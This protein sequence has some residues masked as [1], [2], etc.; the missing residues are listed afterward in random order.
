MLKKS[1]SELIC[2]KF[3]IPLESLSSTPL[4]Q[5]TGNTL[6]SIDGCMSIKKYETDEIIIRSKEYLL[7][8]KGY[9]L[10]MLTFSQGRVNI[11]GEIF[12][13]SIERA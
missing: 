8:I 13:Y 1:F 9:E 4:V 12:S 2:D 7:S 11:K 5:I 6:M 10:S 3:D